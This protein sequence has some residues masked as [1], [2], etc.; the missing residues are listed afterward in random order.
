VLVRQVLLS[1]TKGTEYLG[2]S[3]GRTQDRRLDSLWW[4]ENA[5]LSQRALEKVLALAS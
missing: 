1:V 4:G 3:F 2:Y 5:K